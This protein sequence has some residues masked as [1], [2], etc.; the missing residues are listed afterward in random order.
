MKKET[1]NTCPVCN[2][3]KT[4][5][6]WAMPGYKLEKCG[7][8][9]M[10]WDAYP[11]ENI[12]AQYEK[13]YFVNPNPK[14]GYANYFEGMRVNKRTF[15][16][17][18]KRIGKKHKKGKLLDV[19][20][21][22]GDCLVEAKKL[23]WEDPEGLEVSEYAYEFAKKKGL[24]VKKGFLEKGTYPENNF[25]LVLYQDVIEHI[26]EPVEELEKVRKILK[27][28]GLVF[29]V[30]PDIGG[31]WKRIL[32]PLWYHYKPEEHIMYF[33]QESLKKALQKAGFGNIETRR[34]YHILS[35]EYILNRLRYYSPHLFGFI[36][37]IVTKTSFK[38]ISFKSYTGE[39]EAWGYK[40]K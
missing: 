28:G 40:K 21:A 5:S 4:S 36:L 11:L 19:G 37:K 35:V 12:H 7:N 10:V 23:G 25:D 22:L 27:P 39:I 32:G 14:G 18:L 8:C 2:S 38:D 30:T 33:S 26:K 24:K 9:S 34:T 31:W 1:I 15:Y 17:R 16:E 6:Y 13:S 29:L 20:C 3:K